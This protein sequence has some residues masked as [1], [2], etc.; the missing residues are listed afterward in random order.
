MGAT[1]DRDTHSGVCRNRHAVLGVRLMAWRIPKRFGLKHPGFVVGLEVFKHDVPFFFSFDDA[2][3]YL[4]KFVGAEL[5]GDKD[6][7][8]ALAHTGTA[9]DANGMSY[10][11]VVFHK[12]PPLVGTLAHECAHVVIRICE[13][14]GIPIEA[15]C[16][17][18]FA[19]MLDYL[20]QESMDEL[21]QLGK[22]GAFEDGTYNDPTT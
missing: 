21:V 6:A 7:G 19:Y 10:L 13:E 12:T 18:T 5:C 2:E 14:R 16:D 9:K 1:P 15:D 11:F 20:V 4:R 17:E 8:S 22:E 3:K